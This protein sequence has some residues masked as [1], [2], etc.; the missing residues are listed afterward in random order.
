MCQY[1]ILC[2]CLTISGN[3]VFLLMKS[4]DDYSRKFY[5]KQVRLK[6]VADSRQRVSLSFEIYA[7]RQSIWRRARRR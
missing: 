7:S 3:H 2:S 5:V 4:S 1:K 6:I